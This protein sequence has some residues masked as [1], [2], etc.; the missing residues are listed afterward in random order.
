MA[1]AE[2]KLAQ[3]ERNEGGVRASR[4]LGIDRDDARRATKFGKCGKFPQPV[5]ASIKTY[6][7]AVIAATLSAT[8]ASSSTA[9]L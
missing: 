5:F 2:E 8:E 4:E 7:V 1:D 6:P 3:L 9:C